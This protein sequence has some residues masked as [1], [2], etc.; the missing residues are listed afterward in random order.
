[1][2]GGGLT[3]HA[4]IGAST[5]VFLITLLLTAI[6]A[7]EKPAWT[8]IAVRVAGSWIVAIGLLMLA[9]LVRGTGHDH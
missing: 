2:A 7:W 3:W 8:R 9:W 6:V 5:A 1:M 4:V